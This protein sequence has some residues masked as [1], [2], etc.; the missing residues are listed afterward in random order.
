MQKRPC[1]FLYWLFV[2][3]ILLP[4]RL[5]A[6]VEYDAKIPQLVFTAQELND[7]LKETG[8][9]NLQVALIIKPDEAL[10]EAFQIR[11]VGPTQIRIIGT[12]ATGAMYG[13]LEV[14]DLI[15]TNSVETI[16]KRS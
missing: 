9:E 5:A 12:G 13:G 10:P 14:A 2:L 11:S 15:I 6:A 4:G 16:G 7:A 1:S 3:C 8:R